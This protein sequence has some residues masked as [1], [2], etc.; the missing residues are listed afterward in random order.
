MILILLIT[1]IISILLV[2]SGALSLQFAAVLSA[3]C[4][5]SLVIIVIHAFQR[6]RLLKFRLR[7]SRSQWGSMVSHLGGLPI[8]LETQGLVLL[9]ENELI[10]ESDNLNQ[11][12]KLEHAIS[13]L[14]LTPD[15]L[16]QLND[17]KICSMLGSTRCQALTNARE[18]LRRGDRRLKKSV[19]MMIHYHE[20]WQQQ[21]TMSIVILAVN[22]R[23]SQ[24][25]ILYKN[26]NIR[27]IMKNYRPTHL[28][29]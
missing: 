3:G 17:A 29:K 1:L 5:L 26:E 4:V 15:Q 20:D 11:T 28:K 27:Q 14:L 6:R 13:I 25:S 8:P 24:L 22:Q 23:K 2:L 9:N 21:N 19:I 12:I 7:Q 10:F 18:R 16:R